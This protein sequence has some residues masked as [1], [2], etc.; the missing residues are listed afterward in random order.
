[1]SSYYTRREA[2][3]DVVF[4]VVPAPYPTG[5]G[6]MKLA[7]V[8]SIIIIVLAIPLCFILIGF[9]LL[10]IGVFLFFKAKKVAAAHNREAASRHPVSLLI[11]ADYLVDEDERHALRNI[12]EF[13]VGH[14]NSG[15][16]ASQW[17][18]FSG[19]TAGAAQ[20]VGAN[21]RLRL[22]AA[23]EFVNYEVSIRVDGDSRL[24]RL[25]RG[26]TQQTASALI[27]D[28]RRETTNRVG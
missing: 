6:A 1:M 24:R 8:G 27:D 20:M 22:E 10:L 14:A 11:T 2:G 21:A 25:V 12:R 15:P 26:L 13:L 9:P 28:L 5:A 19:G 23:Q 7:Q 17:V 3:D 18:S 4:D 16:S